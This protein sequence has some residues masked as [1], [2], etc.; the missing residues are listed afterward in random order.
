M[1]QLVGYG[2]PFQTAIYNSL[3]IQMT[4]FQTIM[5]ATKGE[6]RILK[7]LTI[8]EKGRQ[9]GQENTDNH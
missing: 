6:R 1:Y 9:G 5:S 7:M 8:A 3:D 2:I 4:E